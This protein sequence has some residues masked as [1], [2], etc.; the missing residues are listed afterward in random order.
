MKKIKTDFFEKIFYNNKFVFC[1]S[2]VLSV[3]LWATIKMNYSDS[4]TRTISDVRFSIDSRLAQENDFE[5]F[6]EA[7]DLKVDVEISGKSFNVNSFSKDEL[8]VE[9]VSGYV[10]SAGYK[11][12]NITARSNES[13]V[14]V[15]SVSPSTVTVFFD[16]AASDTFNVEAKIKNSEVLEN[17]A[18]Y[19]IGQPVPSL[20]T[21]SVSG[22]ASVLEGL[23]KVKFTASVSEELLPLKE[24]VEIPAKIG[25]DTKGKTGKEFLVCN[26]VGT[27]TNPA[28]ITIPVSKIK[29]VKTAVKF[30]N[31]PQLYTE[32]PP[33]V[34]IEP[35]DVK[36]L[37]NPSDEE[38]E[39]YNVT[40]VDF[41]RLRDGKNSFV[42]PVE[43]KSAVALF[44]KEIREFSVTI[45]LGAMSK[46]ELDASNAKVVFLNQTKGYKYS[47]TLKNVGLDS[48]TIIG[49]ESS[50]KK[51][52]ADMLQ[53]EINVSS[54]ITDHTR[55]QPVDISNISIQSEEIKDCWVYG[56]YRAKV[57]VI[58][59]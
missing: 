27:E 23:R 50:L 24:T 21:V 18:D 36:I 33:R 5:P 13:S 22:P 58:P 19:Y 38:Y 46:T 31:E 15:S 51:L 12:L 49:P 10:D 53:I 45:D 16:K 37:Y 2:L 28:S 39:V 8:V 42:V 41:S 20:S 32:N 56:S 52:K 30:I 55:Y 11:V 6:F 14:T 47:A 7:D 40:T 1:L 54:L 34:T 59:S 57:S 29:T 48:V 35:S 4:T 9:A 25:F 43:E 44:D 3:A 17:T 26:D